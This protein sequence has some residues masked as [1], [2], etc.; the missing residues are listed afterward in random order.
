MR[1]LLT[2]A[3]A[4]LVDGHRVAAHPLTLRRP[5][6]TA[7]S[8]S[9]TAKALV[10]HVAL[11]TAALR[12]GSPGCASWRRRPPRG[13]AAR[14][15]PR[16]ARR[17]GLDRRGRRARPRR[18]GPGIA[19]PR[20]VDGETASASTSTATACSS[21]RPRRSSRA[22]TAAA[23]LFPRVYD[24][25]AGASARDV[26][27][28]GA[29]VE[30]LVARRGDPAMPAGGR[31]AG[32]HWIAASSTR[33]SGG[34]AR[35][36]GAPVELNDA[37]RRR[38]PGPRAWA[39]TARRVR[40][41]ALDRR[42]LRGARLRD[43]PRRRR[44]PGRVRAKN[45]LRRFQIAFGPAREQRF[46]VEIPADPAGDAAHWRDPFWVPLPK[47]MPASCVTVVVTEVA[48]GKEAAPPKSFGAAAIGDLAVFTS[49][50]AR[51][52][53]APGR[54]P[55]GRADCAARLPLLVGLGQAAVLP[56]AQAVLGR[57]DTRANAW[58]RADR[59]RAGAEEPGRAGGAGRGGGG[60]E[61]QGGTAGD[62]R[63][64]E[65]GGRAGVAAG[66][67]ARVGEGR[68][69]GSRARRPRAGRDR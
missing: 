64:R 61:R 34:D 18:C 65:G 59:A 8:T 68:R 26:A 56:T 16:H 44:E 4:P 12:R 30:K 13:R 38:P 48:L 40:H 60:R 22:A 33:A 27:A 57:R 36:L 17:G 50:T 29:G 66:G 20:D 10:A 24:F 45:R 21:S 9:R 63:A 35:A 42:R 58:S 28:A 69:R 19:G 1:F 54:R 46:D 3:V 32:F 67:A 37:R 55:R 39:A 14:S 51:R 7:A 41:R 62:G 43:L 2:A 53:R 5:R 52:G 11:K 25:D 49:S 15:D 47:P 6:R 23:R 31:W